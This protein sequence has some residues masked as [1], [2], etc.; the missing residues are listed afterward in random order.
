MEQLHLNRLGY[1]LLY[2]DGEVHLQVQYVLVA[3][4]INMKRAERHTSCAQLHHIQ[5]HMQCLNMNKALISV[6]SFLLSLL[7]E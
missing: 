7:S 6:C 2:E 5:H 4:C 1:E 3:S